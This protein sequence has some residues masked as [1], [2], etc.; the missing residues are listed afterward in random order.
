MLRLAQG[1][2]LRCLHCRK[3]SATPRGQSLLLAKVFTAS[4]LKLRVGVLAV[5]VGAQTGHETRIYFE[6]VNAIS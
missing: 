1:A 2:L 5:V 4:L 3:V 6:V